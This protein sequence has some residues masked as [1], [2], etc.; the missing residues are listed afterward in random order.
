MENYETLIE[1]YFDGVISPDE[2]T[3]YKKLYAQ[4]ENFRKEVALFEAAHNVA[5]AQTLADLKDQIRQFDKPIDKQSY[6]W[7]KYAASLLIV[8]AAGLILYANWQLTESKIYRSSYSSVPD[9]V[10]VLGGEK[11]LVDSAMEYY[12][13]QQFEKA[14][15]VFQTIQPANDTTLFY[16]GMCFME[17]SEP[18]KA[19]ENLGKVKGMW[20]DIAQYNL[21]L[22]YLNLKQNEKAENVLSK[23]IESNSTDE[24]IKRKGQKLLNKLRN[25][26][27][28]LVF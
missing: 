10:T 28:K 5:N 18:E 21:A 15:K 27:R 26:L 23:L 13:T 7:L 25:P 9:Y 6:G 20:F 3:L 1:K 24:V 2:L 4:D 19:I 12:N 22:A 14:A 16:G 8:G 11:S 17:L